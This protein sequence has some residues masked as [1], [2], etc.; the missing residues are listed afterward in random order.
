MN[1]IRLCLRTNTMRKSIT[2]F[3]IFVVLI[4]IPIVGMGTSNVGSHS[5]VEYSAAK[6]AVT[7]KSGFQYLANIYD[8]S[9]K[10]ANDI[11][12]DETA[13]PLTNKQ[14]KHKGASNSRSDD[15]ASN[16]S[17]FQL[18]VN[19]NSIRNGFGQSSYQGKNSSLV[20]IYYDVGNS[21]LGHYRAFRIHL[22]MSIML[23]LIALLY[24]LP[25]GAIDSYGINFVL[26][27]RVV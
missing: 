17:G 7:A 8:F 14:N 23:A 25:R 6:A 13:V 3:T 21:E 27:Y 5:T 11:V 16:T 9:V 1:L 20:S 15:R 22:L 12:M 24:L 26:E 19:S 2:L 4:N 10:L 18:D